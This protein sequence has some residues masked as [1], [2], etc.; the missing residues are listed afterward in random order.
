MTRVSWAHAYWK[1][2]SIVGLLVGTLFFSASLSPSLVPRAVVL[3][4]ALSGLTLAIGYCFGVFG[5]WL[6]SYLE[7][8]SPERR[9]ARIV[10]N[11]AVVICLL[12]AGNFLLQAMVWQNSIRELM[13]ME[14]LD[15]RQPFTVGS[16]ALVV[17][18]VLI[19]FGRAFQFVF[20]FLSRRLA[21]RVPRRIANA[22]ALILG[23]LI[24]WSAIDGVLFRQALRIADS[25]YEAFDSL[26]DVDLEQPRENWKTGSDASLIDWMSMGTR[27]REFVALAPA[28]QDIASELGQEAIDPLRVYVGLRSADDAKARAR[29]AL[30]EMLRV[31]AFDRSVLVVATPTGTGWMD[32]MAFDTLDYLHRGDVATVAIQYSYLASW[33]SLLVE[34]GYGAEASREL[35]TVVHEHW[36]T[37]PRESRPRL[38]LFGLSLGALSSE[39]SAQFYDLLADPPQG[40]LWAGP[41]FASKFWRHVTS[42][43]KPESPPW[44]PIFGDSSIVRF[45]SQSNA[46]SLPDARWGPLRIVYLQ[47][48]SDPITFFEPSMFFQRPA[49]FA[50]PRGPDVSPKLRWY[51][52]VTALQLGVDVMLATEVP[53]G[54]GHAYAPEH[55]IDG[56]L[57]VTEPPGSSAADVAVLKSIFKERRLE[58]QQ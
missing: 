57:E 45:T 3:Q 10:R 40:A 30:Q 51:P 9:H 55:Y 50:M 54:Y 25:S 2:F 32:P 21:S 16:L 18:L 35:F 8:P 15:G 26:A 38:Y 42:D 29:L 22:L 39:R 47:Y 33:L 4:G 17:F 56:W 5:H 31:G 43:R 1:P 37:L 24:F 27:G 20:R 36:S 12:V 6:W 19:I 46:L 52:I 14:P 53:L 44:L 11:I 48:A 34:P 41:P 58:V 7:L 28:R 13:E 49:W 23:A